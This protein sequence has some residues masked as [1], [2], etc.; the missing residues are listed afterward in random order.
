MTTMRAKLKLTNIV[1]FENCETLTFF[2]VGKSEVYPPDGY[3]ENNTF[4]RW[5]PSA[6]L[7]MTITNPNL[8][9]K[10]E[11]GQEFYVDFTPVVK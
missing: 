4:S 9:D 7:K 8:L 3:D 5:T 1:K 2:A 10:F 6:E 11:L